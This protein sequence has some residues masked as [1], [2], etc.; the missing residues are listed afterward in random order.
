MVCSIC[1]QD[2][3]NELITVLDCG[4]VFHHLCFLQYNEERCAIC[5]RI[6]LDKLTCWARNEH[7]LLDSTPEEFCKLIHFNRTYSRDI[8][9]KINEEKR[10]IR[11]QKHQKIIDKFIKENLLR[12]KFK[13][14]QASSQNESSVMVYV[15]NFSNTYENLPIIYLLNGPRH[16]GLNYFK[17]NGII[18]V[19]ERLKEHFKGCR[20][21]I[22]PVWKYKIISIEIYF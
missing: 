1:H 3:Q 11:A 5:R 22:E 4:H 7:F 15:A 16:E 14:L 12:F 17:K 10:I 20:I 18:S 8:P 13:V 9:W 2:F 19:P 21:H 6:L